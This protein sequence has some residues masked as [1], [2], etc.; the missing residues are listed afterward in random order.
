VPRPTV[1][2]VIPVHN[3]VDQ[4]LRCVRSLGAGT[5]SPD[6][7]VV[8]DGSSDGT[9]DRLRREFPSVVTLR[10]DGD[11]WWAG[12]TNLGVE[13][14]LA[15]GADYVLTVNNDCVLDR[16]AV[17]ALLDAGRSLPRSLV[18]SQR[19]DLDDPG[20][21]WSAGVFFDWHS[22]A[23]LRSAPVGGQEPF[24]VDA[25]GAHSLLVPRQCFEEIGLFDAE[26]LPQNW[27]D[28]DFQLRARA[29]G[30]R[31]LS[32][33]RSIVHVDLSTV[34]PRL[35]PTTTLVDAVRLVSTFRSPY[36]PPHLW[37]FFRRHA[38]P[39]RFPLVM[40]YR[41]LAVAASVARRYRILPVRC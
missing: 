4:T 7:V 6:V 10:A 41:Y 9:G 8:D 22:R 31:V 25:T 11:Q 33:P 23:I 36:Y 24:P 17:E 32:V 21:C 27:A 28:Y 13:H 40:F 5:V 2:A 37:R 35:A 29:A 15:R 19:Y 1:V 3:R 18:A 26:A 12:A 14:A 30:W 16:R 39:P 38:P 34:G 20:T